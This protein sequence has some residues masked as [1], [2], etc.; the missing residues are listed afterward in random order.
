MADRQP[1]ENS[2][3]GER[4]RHEYRA[5]AHLLS[6]NLTG[7]VDLT[8]EKQAFVSLTGAETYPY[9]F[10][11]VEGFS[12]D[13]LMSFRSG[14]ARVSGHNS[15]RHVNGSV[16]LALAVLEH[17]NIL[18]VITADRVVAQVSTELTDPTDREHREAAVTFLGTRFENLKICG[19]PVRM[20]LD[21]GICGTKPSGDRRYLQDPGFLDR[22]QL[23]LESLGQAKGLPEEFKE[24][25][26]S[27]LALIRKLKADRGSN[28]FRGEAREFPSLK[29][30]LVKGIRPISIPGVKTFGNVIVIPDFGILRLADVVVGCPERFTSFA[31][32]MLDMRMGS[33]GEGS[34]TAGNT[35]VYGHLAWRG[36][37]GNGGNEIVAS[38]PEPN[39][40]YPIISSKP[41]GPDKATL[42]YHSEKINR[43]EEP[44]QRVVNTHFRADGTS[45]PS[46]HS[47]RADVE[48]KFC[49]DIGPP[50]AISNVVD[51][52]PI[53]ESYLQPFY[54]ATGLDLQVCL[55]SEQFRI[56]N[57]SMMLRLPRSGPANPLEFTVW[58]PTK[59]GSARLRASIYYRKNLLQ[60]I[61]IT[62]Q[63]TAKTE[64]DLKDGNIA[65][66]EFSLS[67]RLQPDDLPER[68]VN[69]LLNEN[70]EGTHT[71]AVFGANFKKQFSIDQGN[72]AKLA[73]QKLLDICSTR[74]NR[75]NLEYL[76]RD[77]DNSGDEAKL[78]RDLKELAYWGYKLYCHFAVDST[79]AD[80]E[81]KLAATLQQPA[82]IQIA[83]TRSARYVYPWAAVYDKGLVRGPT[84]I[85]CAEALNLL[86]KGGSPGFLE[87]V[88]CPE[89][90]CRHADDVNVICPLRF[91][92]FKHSIEQ[93]AN[94]GEIVR[95]ISIASEPK[96]LMGAHSQLSGAQH[97]KEIEREC[98]LTADY[99]E[100]K[101]DIGRYLASTKPHL[102]YFFCHGGSSSGAPWLGV[103]KDEH[104]DSSDLVA[105]KV[106]WPETRPLVI[107]NGCH[108]VDLSPD[109]LL[110]F[111]TAFAWTRASG[112]IGTEIAIPESLG[113]EF[114]REFLRQFLTGDTVSNVMHRV[115]LRLLEK[116]N[117]LGLAYTPY[118][119]G[120]L[121]VVKVPNRP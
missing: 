121:H 26:S 35:T 58:T 75:G 74:D 30:P 106:K 27:E 14:Y 102:V 65:E 86:R 49:L 18:D 66:M 22:V 57:D 94:S 38:R 33:I 92:G 1:I 115:R 85:V 6:V 8:I 24:E 119:Y 79:D 95:E 9:L 73:R 10:R 56:D 40:S 59:P 54:D 20:E 11:S 63:I 60:S 117:L 109:D 46:S 90:G 61:L 82:T 84:S 52:K 76:Y 12:A 69:I 4:N 72:E 17:L 41:A 25:Y 105:W 104:I 3:L 70:P 99:S 108:T 19:Y 89:N 93:P 7:P 91:W 50:S 34:A 101:T 45:V 43:A 68:T 88:S 16:T 67:N 15:S 71:F 32:T 110:D 13:R 39:F 62:A 23:Q 36:G 81:A 80:F 77:D 112:I 100:T 107:I 55:F 116:Y 111:V 98:H 2:K 97:R 53:P 114:G 87:K 48:Y 78:I 44:A 31:L 118:C 29:F 21:L 113:R 42:P 5:L 64:T 51:A 28:H 47:L 120:D 96:C 103:G 83:S 37:G